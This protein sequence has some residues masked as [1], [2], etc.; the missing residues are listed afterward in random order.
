M[1][2]SLH[3]YYS[4]KEDAWHRA[5]SDLAGL[6]GLPP[7]QPPLL[8]HKAVKPP[9]NET[10]I[11]EMMLAMSQQANSFWLFPIALSNE[12]FYHCILLGSPPE[13]RPWA[14]R[15]EIQESV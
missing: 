10:Y 11:N 2:F 14:Q 9:L 5:R 13:G 6:Q 1:T 8:P 15:D 3:K 7:L 4:I 12:G